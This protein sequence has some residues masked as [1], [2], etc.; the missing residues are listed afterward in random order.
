MMGIVSL[1]LF[2][3]RLKRAINQF[4]M[5]RKMLAPIFIMIALADQT[6]ADL[7]VK[8]ATVTEDGSLS[9]TAQKVLKDKT[10]GEELPDGDPVVLTEAAGGVNASAVFT[11]TETAALNLYNAK[12]AADQAAAGSTE[13]TTPTV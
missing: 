5:K 6:E 3:N 8:S 7:K 1:Y 9:I 10:T 13:S 4:I 2:I 12:L 11:A